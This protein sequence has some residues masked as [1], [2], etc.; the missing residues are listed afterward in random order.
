[1]NSE[2]QKKKSA[3]LIS[4][5]LLQVQENTLISI[6]FARE[7]LSGASYGNFLCYW[8]FKQLGFILDINTSNMCQRNKM[9][10]FAVG[11]HM[12]LNREEIGYLQGKQLYQIILPPLLDL[13]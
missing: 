10:M 4:K 5:L 6:T 13:V 7:N 1:M 2:L 8:C 12:Y 11:L 9:L 3:F